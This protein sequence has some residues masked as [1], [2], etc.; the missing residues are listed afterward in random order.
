MEKAGRVIFLGGLILCGGYLCFAALPDIITD[1]ATRDVIEYL[2]AKSPSLKGANTFE[3][4]ATFSSSIVISTYSATANGFTYL[5]GGILMQW[6]TS[7]ALAQNTS[8]TVTLPKPWPN[9]LL[10]V[11]GTHKGNTAGSGR[12]D[13]S[14]FVEATSGAEK[15]Q[16][17]ISKGAN[18]GAAAGT[19]PVFWIAVGY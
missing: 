18:G 2:E 8:V 14:V 7:A 19:F 3:G 9:G 1:P 12:T 10:S 15:T 4:V 17:T 11:T 6:G 5:P 13:A 16:L